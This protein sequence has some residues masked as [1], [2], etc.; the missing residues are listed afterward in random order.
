MGDNRRLII[1][2]MALWQVEVKNKLQLVIEVAI[3]NSQKVQEG[4]DEI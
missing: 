3:E 4:E 1:N 2:K